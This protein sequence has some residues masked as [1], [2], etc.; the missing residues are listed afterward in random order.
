MP[1][2]GTI[3]R[4][5][6]CA[7]CG[8]SLEAGETW[9][10]MFADGRGRGAI[11]FCP[12]CA[13]QVRREIRSSM[14]FKD[15][16]VGRAITGVLGERIPPDEFVPGMYPED[17]PLH[18]ETDLIDWRLNALFV[19]IEGIGWLFFHNGGMRLLDPTAEPDVWQVSP[20]DAPP[21]LAAL[22]GATISG[23]TPL[24][25]SRLPERRWWWPRPK[26]YTGPYSERGHIF[27]TTKG[28][29]AIA[30]MEPTTPYAV[31]EWPGDKEKW[32]L[33]GIVTELDTE[34]IP[35]WPW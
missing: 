16:L 30:E 31:G 1:E 18:G 25:Y 29:V 4:D 2:P 11:A 19:E 9:Q 26:V 12:E 14:A 33:L 20:D 34:R 13:G 17:E 10:F 28:T 23:I 15:K 7:E 27:E 3:A 22:V 21:P 24:Y 6:T 5:L 8:R 35:G 32:N